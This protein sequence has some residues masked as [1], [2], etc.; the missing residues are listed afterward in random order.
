MAKRYK[1]SELPEARDLE[2]FFTVGTK[3]DDEDSPRSVKMSLQFLKE[4]EDERIKNENQR[5]TDEET[6]KTQEQTRQ[7]NENVRK[8]NEENRLTAEGSRIAEESKRVA[9]ENSRASAEQNRLSAENL[10][11]TQEEER[12]A[13]ENKR[14][15]AES[16]REQDT[17]TSLK[18]VKDATDRL[19]T[20]CD[21]PPVINPVTRTWWLYDLQTNNYKD[22]GILAHGQSPYINP[23]NLHWM[24]WN[25]DKGAFQDSGIVAQPRFNVPSDTFVSDLM[26]EWDETSI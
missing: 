11:K 22:T 8:T 1:I 19:E 4:N 12:V 25:D 24:V 10:R 6:R 26:K 20:I 17:A 3:Y 9:A 21:N 14:V 13:A 18:N 23:E 2:G 5:K 15:S 16:K 7:F